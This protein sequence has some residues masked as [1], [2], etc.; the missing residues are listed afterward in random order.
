MIP[1]VR[2]SLFRNDIK[3]LDYKSSFA[4]GG[5]AVNTA[6]LFIACDIIQARYKLTFQGNKL[7]ESSYRIEIKSESCRA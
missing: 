4:L 1:L 5:H 6:D 7:T 3:I 2:Y